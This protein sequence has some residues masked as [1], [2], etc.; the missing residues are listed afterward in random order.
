LTQKPSASEV[1]VDSN[2]VT[3]IKFGGK[4]SAVSFNKEM[5]RK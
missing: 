4:M 5:S 3:Q 2:V 1:D